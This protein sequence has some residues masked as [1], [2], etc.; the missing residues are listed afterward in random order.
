MVIHTNKADH[1]DNCNECQLGLI[2]TD[3]TQ[4]GDY[5]YEQGDYD[6]ES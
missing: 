1:E 5:E 4:Q 6:Y 3:S 2:E